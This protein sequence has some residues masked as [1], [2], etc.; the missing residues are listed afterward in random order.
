LTSIRPILPSLVLRTTV[1]WIL[2][3]AVFTAFAS[4]AANVV[5]GLESQRIGIADALA[6]PPA[7]ALALA[8]V[9]TL[10]VLFDVR[11]IRERTFLANL[12]V[13]LG[14]VACVSFG[15]AVAF[16]VVVAAVMA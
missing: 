11:A 4:P 16:E 15:I 14:A 12:G 3:R 1:L 13:G 10:L 7:V 6:V 2:L 5:P 8:A 9:V